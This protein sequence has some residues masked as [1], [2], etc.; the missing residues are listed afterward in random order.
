MPIST[1]MQKD[2]EF[3]RNEFG[4]ESVSYRTIETLLYKS[5][6]FEA[7]NRKLRKRANRHQKT[8]DSMQEKI[9]KLIAENRELRKDVKRLNRG[10]DKGKDAKHTLSLLTKREME[11]ESEIE[12][13]KS[14]PNSNKQMF[15]QTQ[16]RWL[17][18]VQDAKKVLVRY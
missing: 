6:K 1:N 11:I 16:E 9:S 8:V 13:L 5:E 10:S 17:K 7:E 15:I 2:I 14:L 4:V 3:I 18:E 12:R